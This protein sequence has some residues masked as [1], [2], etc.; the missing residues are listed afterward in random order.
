MATKPAAKTTT[1][2]SVLEVNFGK[3]D[4]YIIGTTPL[5]CN[6]MSEKALRELL[7]PKGRKTDS[8]KASNL[9]HNPLEEFR[10]SPYRLPDD[11]AP[12][13]IAGLSTWFKKS[14]ATAALDMPG[15][16][17]TQ[18]GR[19]TFV[20]GERVPIYGI[21]QILCS[22]TRSADINKTPDVR[23]RAILP[24]WCAKVTVSYSQPILR[25]KSVLNLIAAAGMTIGV[26]DWR[27]EKGSGNYGSYRLAGPEDKEWKQIVSTGGRAQQI[28]AMENPVAYD[29]DTSE[30]LAWFDVEV[31]RRGFKVAA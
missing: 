22:V 27:G 14:M 12:T 20:E 23:T 6:R 25:E 18:I 17:K 1:E 3:M 15:A 16:K 29:D 30:L 4:L 2:I 19:L 21:P 28:E 31:K 8:D 9:K 5:I 11:D 26:G 7:F 24:K 13:L 10:S